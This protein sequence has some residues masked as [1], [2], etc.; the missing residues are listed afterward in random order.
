MRF[1]EIMLNEPDKNVVALAEAYFFPP[2]HPLMPSRAKGGPIIPR[3]LPPREASVIV[4]NRNTNETS[5]WIVELTTEDAV[6]QG[7]H[8]RG[9]VLSSQL[10]PNVQPAMAS[11]YILSSI[12]IIG[13]L[14]KSLGMQYMYR[15]IHP[16]APLMVTTCNRHTSFLRMRY[17]DQTCDRHASYVHIHCSWL[18]M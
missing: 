4:Y 9:R 15:I 12:N 13:C 17:S 1:V 18:N 16:C 5:I 3:Q 14:E 2:F 6:S 8:H 11:L 10:I 7:G